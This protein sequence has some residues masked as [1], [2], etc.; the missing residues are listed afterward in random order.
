MKDIIIKFIE[1]Q[2]APIIGVV[3]NSVFF[4]RTVVL[5][6]ILVLFLIYLLRKHWVGIFYR[7][8][9]VFE[10]PKKTINIVD[11]PHRKACWWHMGSSGDK[12][13]MQISAKF[14][15]TNITK[16]NIL[17][18]SA[19][20]KKPKALGAVMVKD[21]DSNYHGG[22]SIPPGVTT[23][24]DIDFWIMPPFIN[25]NELFRADIA[26]IDQFGNDHWIK[27]VEFPY[28]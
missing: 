20:M 6:I 17:L 4:W 14:F 2:F 8:K 19:K 27:K 15:V 26:V 7:S 28:A 22:Y 25:Q 13:A 5:I 23:D 10:I 9:V 3:W 24:L 18:T 11:K 21:V 16:Y 12:P 1:K